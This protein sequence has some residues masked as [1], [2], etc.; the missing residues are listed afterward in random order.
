MATALDLPLTDVSCGGATSTGLLESTRGVPAQIAAITPRTRVVT[1]GVGGNDFGLY[2]TLLLTC[3]DVSKPGTTG[4]P[5]RDRL[6]SR[7][8]STVPAIAHN[9]G[10]VLA[11]VAKRAP[12]A[13]ILL[14]GYPRLMPA[15]GT[16]DQAPYAA[17]DVSWISTLE[18]ELAASLATAARAHHVTF[19][20]MHG[21]SKGHDLCSG[22]A[23]WVNGMN[24]PNGD[25]L[26]L[27]PNAAGEAAIARA[28]VKVLRQAGIG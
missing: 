27:H 13:E 20:P 25:G 22:R 4:A 6:G 28:V 3:P 15:N 26:V 18:S 5:C 16:C 24:P 9:V 10:R 23:A 12:K 14:V 19:V 1:V 17:G 8:A 7:F 11:D 21:R 2:G